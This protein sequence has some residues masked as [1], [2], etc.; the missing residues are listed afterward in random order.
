MTFWVSSSWPQIR[1]R[2]AAF[3]TPVPAYGTLIHRSA[4]KSVKGK[5]DPR[6]PSAPGAAQCG[7]KKARENIQFVF[8]CLVFNVDI[9]EVRSFCTQH[10]YG[11][12]LHLHLNSCDPLYHIFNISPTLMDEVCARALYRAERMFGCGSRN[13]SCMIILL[14]IYYPCCR[15]AWISIDLVYFVYLCYSQIVC[16]LW[17]A[18]IVKQLFDKVWQYLLLLLLCF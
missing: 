18:L 17:C 5:A 9:I 13:H 15:F 8:F 16:V 7:G 1:L 14:C 4:Y 10:G 3:Y 12:I 11:Y 2:I 6:S